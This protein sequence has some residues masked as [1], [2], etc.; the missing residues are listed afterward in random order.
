M[1]IFEEELKKIELDAKAIEAKHTKHEELQQV[2]KINEGMIPIKAAAEAE[3][4]E[5]DESE[6]QRDDLKHSE[7]V[8]QLWKFIEQPPKVTESEEDN[9]VFN[10]KKGED[11]IFMKIEPYFI[12]QTSHFTKFEFFVILKLLIGIFV[13]NL[14]MIIL[15]LMTAVHIWAGGIYAMVVLTLVL[16]IILEERAGRF[17]LW[18]IIAAIYFVV[19]LAIL[20]LQKDNIYIVATATENKLRSGLPSEFR[21]QMV[22]LI[23]GKLSSVYGVCVIFFLIILLRINYEKLGFYNKDILA[24]EN[25]PMAVHRV[26]S[27]H[28]DYT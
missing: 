22:L 11:L 2:V 18:M 10:L 19:I 8:G 16:F 3:E 17:Q 6:K 24:V 7:A 27:S 12:E 4:E 26:S 9:F 28:I 1:S 20:F 21:A 14:D 13:S 25:L 15:F 23:V 5:E